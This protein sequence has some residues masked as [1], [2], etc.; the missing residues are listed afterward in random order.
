MKIEGESMKWGPRILRPLVVTV[1]VLTMNVTTTS[2]EATSLQLR[3]MSLSFPAAHLGYVLSLYDCAARTCAALRSTTN[4]A[5]SWNVVP[6]PSQLNT[7]LR[8]ISW[9][10]YGTTYSFSTINVHFANATDGWIYGAIPAR[11]THNTTN[12]NWVLRLWSTHD[13]GKKWRQIRLGP[14]K[15]T[16]GVF[17][18]ATHGAWTYLFGG[19]YENGRAYVLATRSNEDQWTSDSTQP[20]YIPAGGSQLEGAFSFVGSKGWFLAGNDRGFSASAQLANDASWT[21]WGGPSFELFGASFSPISAVT[22]RILIAVG[23]SAGFVTPPASSVPPNWK[24]SASWLS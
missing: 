16:A 10:D 19:S 5:S 11:A 18:M 2:A 13:G 1:F 21:P 9:G 15:I 23:Q 7:D 12:P 8:R 22:S 3:P 6:T 20:M 17:Q 14:L 4:E 24:N